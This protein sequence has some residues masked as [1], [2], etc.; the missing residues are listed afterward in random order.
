MGVNYHSACK[1]I[2]AGLGNL[3][4]N[5]KMSVMGVSALMLVSLLTLALKNIF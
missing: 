3:K 2:Y 1:F 5:L 4:E